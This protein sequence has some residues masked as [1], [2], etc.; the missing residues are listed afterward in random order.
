MHKRQIKR[1][2]ETWV[3]GNRKDVIKE[4]FEQPKATAILLT[5][6]FVQELPTWRHDY[7]TF[8]KLLENEMLAEELSE[9]DEK[10]TTPHVPR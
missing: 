1:L 3:N 10:G 5:A 6:L 9:F 4:I 8:F 2:V 7:Q